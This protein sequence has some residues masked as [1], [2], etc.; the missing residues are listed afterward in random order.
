MKI[1]W[2]KI[3]FWLLISV[4]VTLPLQVTE[5]LFPIHLLG[6]KFPVLE[7]SRILTAI[8]ILALG[9]KLLIT[10]KIVFPRDPLTVI[11]YVFV[12]ISGL[13]LA[14]FRSNT[15]F[16]EVLRYFFHLGFFLLVI[17]VVRD[18]SVFEKIIRAILA[19]GFVISLFSIFQY[20][21]GF[22]LW[23][24]VLS[25]WD[26]SIGQI[27]NRVNATFLNPNT[28]ASFLG[29]Q[30]LFS[31]A[32]YSLVTNRRHKV[33]AALVAS[34][35]IAAL[36]YTFSRA[37][38]ASF[39]VSFISLILFLP[40]NLKMVSFYSLLV[41]VTAVVYVGSK[42]VQSRAKNIYDVVGVTTFDAL[43]EK[44]TVSQETSF[45]NI[46]NDQKEKSKEVP[47]FLDQ[48]LS[49]LPLNS[50]RLA[51]TKAGVLMFLDN[52]IFGVGLSNFQE[53]YLR[54][55]SFLIKTD[56]PTT[57]SHNSFVTILAEFGII[58][59]IWITT[60]LV[61]LARYLLVIFRSDLGAKSLMLAVV[62]SLI[63]LILQSQYQ[64]GLFEDPYFWLLSGLVVFGRRFSFQG[65][66]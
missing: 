66:V 53:T 24:G 45:S 56:R 2:D 31:T 62:S 14:V 33:L 5:L 34:A 46:S 23:N 18:T 15:G 11:L 58:G 44:G 27:V 36:S 63:L 55:Y 61:I 59:L 51:A 4:V 17:N 42:G 9:V 39:G 16:L 29:I 35:S 60:L 12:A 32:Y 19:G 7:V 43:E 6:S 37:G 3:L 50:N 40:K 30:I 10:K 28:L 49:L 41:L 26:E 54:E 25:E 8:G 38:W 20:F 1:N 52:P 21:S 47:I 22:Y 48:V 64:G 65:V 57:L 13:S